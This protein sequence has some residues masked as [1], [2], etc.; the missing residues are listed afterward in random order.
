LKQRFGSRAGEGLCQAYGTL[1]VAARRFQIAQAEVDRHVLSS[2]PSSATRWQWECVYPRPYRAAVPDAARE[3]DVPEALLYAVMRQ[4]SS[5][6]PDVASSAGARG[7]MQLLPQTAE[8]VAGELGE[9]FDPTSL[10]QPATSLRFS[11]QYLSKL[12]KAFG[13]NVPLA[14][15]AYN[16]GPAALRR[17]LE[18]GKTLPLDVF[19]ARIP[20]EETLEYVERVVGNFARYRYLES[21]ASGVPRLAL[22]LPAIGPATEPEY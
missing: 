3:A 4:E 11:A 16:A 8:K 5:F 17:W 7:L 13:A 10:S 2:A 18:G 20:Y 14:A 22:E 19:V 1:D 6:K 9:P 21:G 15:A 12:L